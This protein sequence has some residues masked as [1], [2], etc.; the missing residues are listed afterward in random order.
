MSLTYIRLLIAIPI[1][2]HQGVMP[3][4][5]S[6][7]THHNDNARTGANLSET[8]L[9]TANVNAQQF[10][11]L[12][13][14]PVDGEVYAQPLY[15]PGVAIAGK[16][17]H[18]VVFV[19]TM[20]DSVYAFDADSNAGANATPLWFVNFTNPALGITAVPPG[21]V[22]QNG[23]FNIHGTVGIL[24]T[25]VIDASA[26]IIYVVART[27][28]NGNYFFRLH[29]LS[30][31]GGAEKANS[32][33][34][35]SATVPGSG[36]D[37]VGGMVTFN[38]FRGNQR[39]A[40][41]LANGVVYIAFA[42]LGDIDP[43]H[44]WLFGYSS[45]TMQQMSVWNDTP[46]GTRG[47]IWQSGNGE[48]VDASGSLY[49]LTGNGDWDGVKNF[50]S[51]ITKLNPLSLTVS[52]YFTPADY[53]N[54]NQTDSD[55]GSSG[56]L[57]IPDT[58]LIAGGGKEGIL[59]V[60]PTNNLGHLQN[61]NTKQV[62]AFQ[63]AVG[64]IHGAPVYWRGPQGPLIYVWG[65]RSYFSAYHFNGTTF[66]TT[67][68]MQ[69]SFPAPDGMP[70]AALSLSAN[71]SA[72]G[73]G[74]VWASIPLNAD[75]ETQDVAGVLRAFD[76]NN[77]SH[78]LWNSQTDASRDSLG[79]FAKYSP[80]T[81]ANG[82]VYLSTFSNQLCVYGV[83]SPDFTIA[84]PS[85]AQGVAQG[86]SASF[87][88]AVTPILGLTTPVQLSAQNLP[89]GSTATFNP[90]AV[91]GTATSVLT[92][93]TGKTTPVGS[94][95]VT[96]TG[97][98]GSVT[99]SL[100]LSLLM[101]A[102]TGVLGGVMTMPTTTQD[103]TALGTGDWTHWGLNNAV[104]RKTGVT[105]SISN[106]TVVGSAPLA[107]YGN[108]P[109][110]YSWTNGQPDGVVTNTA[111]GVYVQGA[112]NGFQVTVPAD[113]TPRTV[114]VYA[115]VYR[116]QATVT[117]QLSDLSAATYMNTALVNNS[118]ASSAA[119]AITYQA[120]SASQ[121]LT[122]TVVETAPAGDPSGN[123]TL[124]SVALQN[125]AAPIPDFTVS[126]SPA[127]VSMAAG[128]MDSTTITI[129]ALNGFSGSASL[130]ASGMPA[131]VTATFQP[132]ALTPGVSNLLFTA[133]ANAT[134]GTFPITIQAVSGNLQHQT[135]LV[136]TV[137]GG[138]AGGGALSGS[139][140]APQGIQN[141]TGIGTADWV[142]WG[143][144]GPA[145]INR[146]AGG[147]SQISNFTA[148]AGA[149][150]QSYNN[151]PFGFSWNNGTPTAIVTQTSAGVYAPGQNKGFQF[152][153]P[154]DL[155]SRTLS[156]FAGVYKA[157]AKLTAVLS[158]G[159]A[160]AFVDTSVA[161]ANGQT[162]VQYSLTYQAASAGQTLTITL[163]QA[164]VSTDAFSNV[165]LQGAALQ[166]AAAPP[167]SNLSGTVTIPTGTQNLTALG[168]TDWVHWIDAATPDRKAAVVAQISPYT[169]VGNGPV[170]SYGNNPF[171]FSWT[172]GTPIAAVPNSNTGVWVIG[173]GNGFSLTAPADANWRTLTVY[174]G[175]YK[176]T[177][178]LRAVLSDGSSPAFTDTSIS[179]AAGSLSA[180]YT[181]HYRANA[182]GQTLTVTYTQ[183]VPSSDP[184]SNVTLQSAALSIP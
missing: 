26:G 167:P 153:V 157:Q 43:Y 79:L 181:L 165:T 184:Y 108:N 147:A 134:A 104:D 177:G 1:I 83:F 66:D 57:L 15:I 68:V 107:Y 97:T 118:N 33:V 72:P 127:I 106:L 110:G 102:G 172:D 109:F 112:G 173:Q 135:T 35:I 161:N 94:Y 80:P 91:T 71:G 73:S 140:K 52:D 152:S 96:V 39:T 48:A 144:N 47:G 6:V 14:Y 132:A 99:H 136:L 126:V 58:N 53:Q 163:V 41:T 143:L 25:P 10:G 100:T 115:G 133:A 32:P 171:A 76:A 3:A 168:S 31:S 101:N 117:A 67:A 93:A 148:V 183:A 50:G 164:N 111:T 4:Q 128:S 86:S 156:I 24:S 137:T 179:S 63:A 70:G 158:D 122:I 124:Q 169:L 121:K 40:L 54:E 17:V 65:E 84:S 176:T 29:A 21:D 98:A 89:P 56:P 5:V 180:A 61:A 13:K 116:A 131:N 9:T 90:S 160:P 77:L 178:A 22:Q 105:A 130:T 45:S 59:F 123:V 46:N 162:S 27:K 28:E 37:A 19:A 20:N 55:L 7:W 49:L 23:D 129:G 74:V 154:A 113:T 120:A 95:A 69:S 11:M 78:E 81:I 155:T 44:G 174:A 141:L 30:L 18:N 139:V 125:L 175:V 51:S 60:G 150:I 75:A 42:S 2:F 16:G 36:Y 87:T 159:S 151:N 62:Q 119:Y 170:L 145:S 142:H 138:V 85:P 34:T 166:A 103:L 82:K 64:H 38:P 182:P 12:F 149:Q 88:V 8:T 92:I 114:I 146:R